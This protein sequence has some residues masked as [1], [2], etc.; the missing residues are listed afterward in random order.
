MWGDTQGETGGLAQA[1]PAEVGW[2]GT[3]R[4][5]GLS[6]APRLRGPERELSW[7]LGSSRPPGAQLSHG[8]GV[9]PLAPPSWPAVRV[10]WGNWW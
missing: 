1:C 7:S 5:W 3:G 4:G 6:R 10:E 2:S 8:A 9:A